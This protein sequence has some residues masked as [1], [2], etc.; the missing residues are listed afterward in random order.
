MVLSLN[1]FQIRWYFEY[2]LKQLNY[3]STWTTFT[4]VNVQS[5][6]YKCEICTFPASISFALDVPLLWISCQSADVKG[7]VL[8]FPPMQRGSF[9]TIKKGVF[10]PL[11][12]VVFTVKVLIC[13]D[14]FLKCLANWNSTLEW[15][16]TGS[17][18]QQKDKETATEG[19]GQ[20]TDPT[21]YFFTQRSSCRN[22]ICL[23]ILSTWSPRLLWSMSFTCAF[24]NNNRDGWKFLLGSCWMLTEDVCMH[25]H[26]CQH[27]SCFVNLRPV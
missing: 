9:A 20:Q 13:I 5:R 2:Q 27:F 3:L 12:M 14:M 22:E 7:S 4:Y 8:W 16:L 17:K 24:R 19:T 26:L 18:N 1:F 21:I 10:Y 25:F 15:G 11:F 23:H 6:V